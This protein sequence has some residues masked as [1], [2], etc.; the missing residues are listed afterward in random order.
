MR[1]NNNVLSE[2]LAQFKK[3]LQ[4]RK[5][6]MNSI[7]DGQLTKEYILTESNVD[8]SVID[9][10]ENGQK[11]IMIK[12]LVRMVVGSEMSLILFGLILRDNEFNFNIDRPEHLAYLYILKEYPG[13][14]IAGFD[15]ELARLGIDEKHY[16]GKVQKRKK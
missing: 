12:S 16:L 15:K 4:D 11:N 10:W 7:F 5:S 8:V 9:A 2:E 3:S 1:E 14:D 13:I 6:I